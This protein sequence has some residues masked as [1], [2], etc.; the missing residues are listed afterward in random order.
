ME[1]KDL[2]DF[3]DL[4]PEA[5]I[6]AVERSLGKRFSALASPLPS[7]IN[8]VFEFMA[9]DGTRYIAK[10][11]RPGRWSR[12]AI[13]EEHEFVLDCVEDEIPVVPPIELPG[14][15]TLTD[16]DGVFFAVYPKRSGREMELTS[17]ES[18]VRLGALVART[19]NAGARRDAPHR[20]RLHPDTTTAK[21][22][23]FLLDGEFVPQRL[24]GRFKSACSAILDDVLC[25]F[26]GVE[27]IRIHGDCHRANILERPGEGLMVI[28]FDDMMTGPPVQ[29]IWLLLPGRV[30]KC[31]RE[32]DLLLDGYEGL[33]DFDDSTLRLVEPLRA[34][35][36]I[37]FL[38]WCAKQSEDYSF[39]THYPDWGGDSFW[40]SEI[41][42]LETQKS[43]IDE[44]S[45]SWV[46]RG[47]GV[48]PTSYVGRVL[49]DH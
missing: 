35:R 21:E 3:G 10:F 8:R 13:E 24:A 16:A 28:D 26:E 29:D 19:H 46:G 36:M 44:A 4:T 42:D 22:I 49:T 11:Y 40:M 6:E 12:E 31:R 38:A 43:A 14:G 17:D 20:L 32:I 30:D 45:S 33:R 2:S 34:M 9:L 1:K 5:M 39:R 7:Y 18:W 27:E 25:L 48:A 37:Y 41:A 47:L 23:E 15:G